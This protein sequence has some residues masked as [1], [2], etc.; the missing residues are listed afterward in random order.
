[1]LAELDNLPTWSPP[2]PAFVTHRVARGE[3]L[4]V[5]AKKY[6]TG[7]RNIM[8]MNRISNTNLI[9]AGSTLKVPTSAARASAPTGTK[10]RTVSSGQTLVT[11]KVARGETLSTIA[12]RYGTGIGNIKAANGLSNTDLIRAGST[13]RI[14]VAGSRGPIRGR[15]SEY[16]VRKGDSLWLIAQRFGTTVNAI[17]TANGLTSTR[18]SIGQSLTLPGSSAAG[19]TQGTTAAPYIVRKGDSPY[20]IAQ[21]YRMDLSDFLRLNKLTPRSTIYPGQKLLVK[22][23]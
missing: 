21:K 18:L 7:V 4:S 16:K 1:L 12:R 9:R 8:A 14:P 3:T 11:H 2:V 23:D 15:P 19:A 5:I 20:L 17:Q 22:A 10:T 13:L 6:G